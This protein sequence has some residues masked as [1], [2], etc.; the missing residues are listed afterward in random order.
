MC[1]PKSRLHGSTESPRPFA[2][3][4][5]PRHFERDRPFTIEHLALDLAFDFR[6]KSIRE[7]AASPEARRPPNAHAV[8]LAASRSVEKIAVRGQGPWGKKNTRID[9]RLLTIDLPK[10]FDEV[11]S[12]SLRGDAA[13]GALLPRARRPRRDAA[14]PG[15]T[16]CQAE[17][18]R[19]IFPCHEQ[20]SLQD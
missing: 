11:S 15:V 3:A 2:F 14:A 7:S 16:Q 4:S 12:R 8:T 17:D 5:S 20:A 18:A 19:H 9:G 13:E 6:K 1:S 10:G